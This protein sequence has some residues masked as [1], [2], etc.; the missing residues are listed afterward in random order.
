M[1]LYWRE[2]WSGIK[3]KKITLPKTTISIEE[4]TFNDL[5]YLKEVNIPFNVSSKITASYFKGCDNLPEINIDKGNSLYS[6][7]D[8]VLYNKNQTVII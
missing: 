8:G 2:S 4:L 1:F 7:D 3:I 5:K 6:S